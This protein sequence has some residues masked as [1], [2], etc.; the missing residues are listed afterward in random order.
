MDRCQCPLLMLPPRLRQ[1]EKP[2]VYRSRTRPRQ[3][4]RRTNSRFLSW[5]RR[6][7]VQ[8]KPAR[9]R[10]GDGY[11]VT[12]MV[13]TAPQNQ[14]Y[15]AT[16]QAGYKRCWACGSTDNVAGEL[17]CTNCGAQ[18]TGRQYRLYE[19]PPEAPPPALPDTLRE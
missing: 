16:D 15:L 17:Y 13:Q 11:E 5:A 8:R 4:S 3:Q 19:T 9:T 6:T 7:G 18:L 1:M 2:Q 10:V 14:T 12:Q